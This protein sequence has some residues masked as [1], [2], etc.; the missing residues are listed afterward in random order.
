VSALFASAITLCM[1]RSPSQ[2]NPNRRLPMG[3]WSASKRTKAVRLA[4]PLLHAHC[5]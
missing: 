2:Q 4:S 1:S 3:H 5:A